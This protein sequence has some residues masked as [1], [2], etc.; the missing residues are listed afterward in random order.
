MPENYT[1]TEGTDAL[2]AGY[3][4]L[5]G[6]ED[7][8]DGWLAINKTRD[9]LAALKTWVQ[10][11]IAGIQLTWGAII[12]PPATFPPSA[13]THQRVENGPNW[14]GWQ[15]SQWGTGD[16]VSVGTDLGVDGVIY[17]GSNVR[18][19]GHVFVPAAT[20]ATAGYSVAYINE[21]GRLS[22]N[23]S[24]AKYKTNIEP[25]DPADLGDI[26]PQLSRYQMRDGD[27]TWKVGYIADRLAENADQQPFVVYAYAA[28]GNGQNVP[29][30]EVESI[31]FI[32][33]L[34]AQN[35]QLHQR[36]A[37]LEARGA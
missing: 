3:D 33:L 13:H 28:D 16:S 25:L 14:F 1:G 32:A 22:R 29:T 8:R 27:G 20:P 9:Y 31:D 7:R 17:A 26:W 2:A 11:Q 18:V 36:L 21:D 4:I 5:D 6:T 35:A 30:D 23:A 24:A 37:A 10:T 34:I 15:G 19:T 12:D